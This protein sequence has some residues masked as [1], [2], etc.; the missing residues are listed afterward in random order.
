LLGERDRIA[1][2][3]D[4]LAFF[5]MNIQLAPDSDR[6]L[7][8]TAEFVC[9]E[10]GE[11][12]IHA[13]AQLA[14]EQGVPCSP[15][16]DR[17]GDYHEAIF[18]GFEDMSPVDPFSEPPMR[19]EPWPTDLAYI[20]DELEWV[21]LRCERLG[22]ERRRDATPED[23]LRA[24]GGAYV[25]EARVEPHVFA[26]RIAEMRLREDEARATL[27]ARLVA[28]RSAG[29]ELGLDRMVQAH[30]LDAFERTV[31]LLAA[32]PC[33]SRRFERLYAHLEGERHQ[34][35]TVDVAFS[36]AGLSAA[37]RI[38]HRGALGPRGRLVLDDLIDMRFGVS[39]SPK[40]LLA[41]DIELRGRTFSFLLGDA[42]LGDE[43]ADLAKLEEPRGTF[44][45]LVLPEA[46]RQRILAVIDGQDRVLAARAAWGLNESISYGRG[47]ILLFDGPPGTG[48][49]LCAHAIAARLGRRVMNV[50]AAKFA[51]TSDGA[52]F[53]PALFREARLQNALLFFD[54]CEALLSSRRLGN[55]LMHILLTEL[56]RFEG[57]CVLA[58]NLP[59]MLD[60]ALWRRALVRVHFGKPEHAARAEIWRSLLPAGMPLA[61][62]V[63]LERL[64]EIEI[65]GGA[66]KNAI[67][68]AAAAAVYEAGAVASARVTQAMLEDAANAQGAGR[69][70]TRADLERGAREGDGGGGRRTAGFV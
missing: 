31:L 3:Q 20:E 55:S 18:A 27:D 54:E 39:P 58:T 6:V 47:T 70:I 32:G 1:V 4:A 69:R 28:H 35:L 26:A 60:D 22:L 53:V 24:H 40:D 12:G 16:F 38:A 7:L 61:A 37:D 50:D 48:K 36:F 8:C 62:D 34:S 52:S 11:P 2:L 29:R 45:R 14:T 5:R 33:V 67:L 30:G 10:E 13:A 66:I 41:T 49:T 46:N 51:S 9:S 63:D 59:D 56:E 42:S 25:Q 64:S 23:R 57:T 19:F 65:A 43:L 21:S 68:T 17:E 44:D 15:V